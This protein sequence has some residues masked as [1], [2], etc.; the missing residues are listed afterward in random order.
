MQMALQRGT[1]EGLML[2][3]RVNTEPAADIIYAP[4]LKW[5]GGE[6]LALCDLRIPLDAMRPVIELVPTS[7]PSEPK[8][9]KGRTEPRPSRPMDMLTGHAIG[10]AM[11]A[12]GRTPYKTRSFYLDAA[13]LTNEKVVGGGNAIAEV[14]DQVVRREFSAIPVIRV[15]PDGS[16]IARLPSE[17]QTVCYRFDTSSGRPLDLETI[18]RSAD[19]R[20]M[21]LILD[22][23]SVAGFYVRP[24]AERMAE[25]S[26]SALG[27]FDTVILA[28]SA[29]PDGLEGVEKGSTDRIDR[30]DLLAW[31]RYRRIA[32]DRSL[33]VASYGDYGIQHPRL[34]VSR[35]NAKQ[36]AGIRYTLDHEWLILR[37]QVLTKENGAKQFVTLAKN[38]TGRADFM[39]AHHCIGC[40][41]VQDTADEAGRDMIVDLG[42]WRHYGTVHHLTTTLQQILEARA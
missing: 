40:R 32:R 17:G 10:K 20:R 41:A 38:L 5:K 25:Q 37:G 24:V 22:F 9:K 12:V 8:P 14:Y 27:V 29:F 3:D 6:Q 30:V 36:T 35:P 16:P 1:V 23:C 39:G 33:L 15:P 26:P 31:R 19:G 13:A 34:F 42:G 18:R 21:H 4:I 2:Q 11:D 7:P 28:A